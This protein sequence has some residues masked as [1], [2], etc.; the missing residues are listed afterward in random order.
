[1][2]LHDQKF[3]LIKYCMMNDLSISH[4]QR[5][6]DVLSNKYKSSFQCTF[7]SSDPVY[8]IKNPIMLPSDRSFEAALIYFATDNYLVNIDSHNQNFY[9]SADKGITWKNI[10][11]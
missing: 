2:E 4:L 11:Q 1:M 10:K 9:Y 6:G 8:R 7:R 5:I 3:P